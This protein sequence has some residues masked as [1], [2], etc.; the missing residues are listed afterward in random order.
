MV[1]SGSKRVSYISSIKN[2]NQGGGSKKAG[3]PYII[4]RRWTTSLALDSC[5]NNNLKGPGVIPSF[6]CCPLKSM[7]QPENPKVNQSRNIGRNN[8]ESYWHIPGNSK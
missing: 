2:R 8:N 1:L 7:Q 6:S 3:F 5:Y 4:G